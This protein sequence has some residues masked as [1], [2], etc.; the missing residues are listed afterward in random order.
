MPMRDDKGGKPETLLAAVWLSIFWKG[1]DRLASLLKHVFIASAIGLSA[2]LDVF[3]M[4]TGLLGVL[5]LS[6]SGIVDILAIPELVQYDKE[7]DRAGF[8]SL[9]GGLFSLCLLFSAGLALFIYATWDSWTQLALGFKGERAELLQESILWLLPLIVFY[10]P[11]RFLG[12]LYRARRRFS[13]FYQSEFVVSLAILLCVAVFAGEPHV[14]LWSYSLGVVASFLY[15]LVPSLRT[16]RLWGSPFAPEVTMLFPLLPGLLILS[17]ASYLF[18]LIQSQLV[19]LLAEGAVGAVAYAWTLVSLPSTMMNVHGAFITVY[20]ENRSNSDAIRVK[21]DELASM[22]ITFAIPLAVIFYFFGKDLVGL[23]LERG[24][25]SRDN[26][27]LVGEALSY[28]SLSVLP[29]SLIGPLEQVFRVERKLRLIVRRIALGISLFVVL[30]VFFVLRC[31]WGIKGVAL[32]TSL[33]YWG[34]LVALIV[35]MFGLGIRISIF[36]H[37]RWMLIV[38]VLALAAYV[39]ASWLGSLSDSYLIV[40]PQG[41]T[42][43]GLTL[44]GAACF[45]YA[46]GILVRQLASR[47]F[48]RLRPKSV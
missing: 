30:C 15:L 16:F 1:L 2:Q 13:L 34:M 14:L 33:S 26:T 38:A 22:S 8:E 32:A 24:M 7:G 48:Q 39:P 35:S 40:V 46:D 5:V 6:W 3:Y 47:S 42:V 28:F 27:E 31:Q 12:S 19:S 17:G 23:L 4:A 44:L 20:A 45:S 10:I 9:T 41:I 37:L 29:F 18:G 43:L 25:F 36:R 21:L 11:A